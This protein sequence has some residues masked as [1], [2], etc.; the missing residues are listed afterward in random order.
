MWGLLGE[1]KQVVYLMMANDS[2]VNTGKATS[3]ILKRL[4]EH[5]LNIFQ[6]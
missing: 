1:K 2:L 5:D 6:P 3:S 4:K